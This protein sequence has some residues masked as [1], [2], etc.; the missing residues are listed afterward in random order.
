M[1]QRRSRSGVGGIGGPRALER[2]IRLRPACRADPRTASGRDRLA[3]GCAECFDVLRI[4]LAA[5]APARY[6]CALRARARR[7]APARPAFARAAPRPADLARVRGRLLDDSVTDLLLAALE[8]RI[9]LREIRVA[10]HVR[11]DERVL[12]QRVVAGEIRAAGI[13]WENHLEQPRMTH[14]VLDQLVDVAHAERPVRHAHRQTIDGDLHHEARRHLLEL[15][16]V[17]VE[18]VVLARAP[19]ATSRSAAATRSCPR[20][21]PRPAC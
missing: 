8:Q 15:H 9:V 16:G 18:A 6:R 13:A 21:P 17:I 20:P 12:L 19:R 3:C 10:E 11:R 14:P 4:R 2:R 1:N 7:R 5:Q